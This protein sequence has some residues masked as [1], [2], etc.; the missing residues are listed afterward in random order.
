MKKLIFA[1]AI[2]LAAMVP[3]ASS[4]AVPCT[5][6][7]HD[8]EGNEIWIGDC[9][10]P[11]PTPPTPTPTPVPPTATPI[12]PTVAPTFTPVPPTPT[13][14][15]P[16]ATPTPPPLSNCPARSGDGTFYITAPGTYGGCVFVCGN[17]GANAHCVHIWNSGGVTLQDF[18]IQT[19]QGTGLQFDNNVLIRRGTIDGGANGH[20]KVNVTF[21]DVDVS[22]SSDGGI[23]LFGSGC[24]NSN[25][26][27]NR[28]IKILNSTFV[29]VSGSEMLYMKCAQDVLVQGNTFTAGSE[30]AT[31]FP[32]GVNIDIIGNV[33][34][35]TSQ[36]NWLAIE[37]PKVIDTLVEGN[38]VNSGGTSDTLVYV[39]S[40]TNFL[41]IRNNCV[42]SNVIVLYEGH[43]AGGVVN[44]T[45]TNNGPCAGQSIQA[46]STGD[47][48]IR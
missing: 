29:N 4:E 19:P 22:R 23:G 35:L 7:G 31:S 25:P 38:R 43:Q 11:T 47:G 32:D 24:E 18:S 33:F 48:G 6:F 37:L 34:N 8:L 9:G 42:P 41:I 10:T 15:P 45:V 27:P 44:K 39:N 17:I 30:W 21:D 16:T 13:V 40:G 20:H 2:V 5:L 12:P 1:I 46:P 3:A 36:N 14:I 26:R 28:N